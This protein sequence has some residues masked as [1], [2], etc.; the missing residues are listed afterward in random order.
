MNS[1]VEGYG[2][3]VSP[4][5]IVSDYP[6]AD[7]LKNGRVLIAG[8]SGKLVQSYMRANG[9]SLDMCYKTS[10]IK[11]AIPG[12]NSKAVK[13]S[14]EALENI[15]KIDNWDDILIDE[16]KRISPNAIL[17]LGELPMNFLTNEKK[18]N[19]FRGSILNLSSHNRYRIDPEKFIRVVPTLHPRDI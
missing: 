1:V 3:N 12:F 11:C 9:Y 16:I 13:Q 7:E 2:P 10:Y 19:R 14:Q 18:I 15:K 5:M 4:L 8:E 6:T 17:T